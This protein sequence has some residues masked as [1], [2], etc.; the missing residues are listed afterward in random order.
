M[1]KTADFERA[2]A[3]LRKLTLN[4]AF[5]PSMRALKEICELEGLPRTH[6]IDGKLLTRFLNSQKSSD[7]R[8]YFNSIDALSFAQAVKPKEDASLTCS[9][10][11]GLGGL[12]TNSETP[13]HPLVSRVLD[14]IGPPRLSGRTSDLSNL[15]EMTAQKLIPRTL[16]V[17]AA[18]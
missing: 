15:R 12:E 2:V 16:R 10:V 7:L 5:L 9:Y 1:S 11:M 17:P 14:S 18:L 3:D 6:D 13:F 8:S 4:F